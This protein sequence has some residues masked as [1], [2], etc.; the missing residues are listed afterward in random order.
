MQVQVDTGGVNRR[1]VGESRATLIGEDRPQVVLDGLGFRLRSRARPTVGFITGAA[2][3][4]AAAAP[5]EIEIAV[6]I[7][8]AAAAGRAAVVLI[9]IL[10]PRQTCLG[11]FAAIG[12][13]LQHQVDFLIVQNPGD[14]RVHVVVGNQVF[15]KTRR[16]LSRCIFTR[17]DGRGDEKLRLG[18][19]DGRVGQH[20]DVHVVAAQ[21]HGLLPRIADINECRQLGVV[22]HNA[23]RRGERFLHGAVAWVTGNPVHLIG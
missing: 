11:L 17:V 14:I 8:A 12:I 23:L 6:E 3:G 16:Q 13:G 20:Q 9:R 19:G 1:R 22:S 18:S 10:A 7:G 5:L 15:G 2:A 21:A 4:T